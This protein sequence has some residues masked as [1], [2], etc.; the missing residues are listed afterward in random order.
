MDEKSVAGK[1]TEEGEEKKRGKKEKGRKERKAA[2]GWATE[3]ATSCE[4]Q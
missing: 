1:P 2:N 4:R 3:E